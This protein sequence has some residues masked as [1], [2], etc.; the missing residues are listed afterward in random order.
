VVGVGVGESVVRVGV[1]ESVV[2]VGVGE[3]LVIEG[4]AVS[5]KDADG[6]SV[7]A[8]RGRLA[9]PLIGVLAGPATG[10]DRTAPAVRARTDSIIAQ[11]ANTI[12]RMKTRRT[13]LMGYAPPLSR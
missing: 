13:A 3:S 8:P 9:A 12:E 6:E 10:P 4:M 7:I 2:R 11:V 1:G 5:V